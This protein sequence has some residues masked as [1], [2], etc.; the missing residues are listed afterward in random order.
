[1][2]RIVPWQNWLFSTATAFAKHFLDFGLNG[3]APGIAANTAPT[4]SEP[5][6]EDTPA[7]PFYREDEI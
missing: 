6:E 1:M 5:E 2:L 7:A 3:A 4:V